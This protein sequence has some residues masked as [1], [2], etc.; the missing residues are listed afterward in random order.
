MTVK[1]A[2]DVFPNFPNNPVNGITNWLMP[3]NAG[4]STYLSGFP[5]T[6]TSALATTLTGDIN[7]SVTTLPVTSTTGF[8]N[9]FGRVTIGTEKILYEYKDSTNFYGCIRGAEQSTAA[10]HT[11]ADAVTENNVILFYSR[12]PVDIQITTTAIPAGTL[13]MVLE[14]CDEHMEGIIKAVVFNLLLKID[15]DRAREFKLDY[16]AKYQEY[17]SD[18]R[19]GYGKIQ[20]NVNIRSPF[21]SN[22]SG[23]AYGTNLY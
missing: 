3:W 10:T 22:E 6:G 21:S 4:H 11:S 13:A 15:M 1:G 17:A 16:E 23:V 14:P 20:Q 8:I 7:A 18:I 5:N 19:K 9:N 12:L 2:R